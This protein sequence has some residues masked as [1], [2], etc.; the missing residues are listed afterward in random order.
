MAPSAFAVISS[1][2][3]VSSRGGHAGV[4]IKVHDLRVVPG[5]SP[6]V[7]V[8]TGTAI[9]A[10]GGMGANWSLFITAVGLSIATAR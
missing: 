2:V 9:G 6:S 3:G 10:T 5:G 1:G 4:H 7:V 8:G